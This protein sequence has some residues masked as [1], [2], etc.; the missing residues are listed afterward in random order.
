MNTQTLIKS[1]AATAVVALITGIAA[2]PASAQ[3][4]KRGL[5]KPSSSQA[6]R[7]D[8]KNIATFGNQI[9]RATAKKV[10]PKVLN[11]AK[12]RH[13]VAK[14]AMAEKDRSLC[15][16]AL[17][18]GH[19]MLNR[20]VNPSGLA[21][22]KHCV[23]GNFKRLDNMISTGT[24]RK[25]NPRSIGT[26]KR[27]YATAKANAKKNRPVCGKELK[28]GLN[29]M[30]VVLGTKPGSKL[31]ANALAISHAKTCTRR[32]LVNLEKLIKAG[33]RKKVDPKAIQAAKREYST[34][35][36]FL[37]RNKT[38]CGQALK[39]GGTIMKTALRAA[40]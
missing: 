28:A 10:N 23:P 6:L 17:R 12:F 8:V 38:S 15:T 16:V 25:L 7:C 30:N 37:N 32:N 36:K 26:A 24:K 20:A 14:R 35:K 11:A 29:L 33:T 1:V 9:K 13:A 4:K 27:H 31:N 19:A 3:S 22:A 2:D 39:N 34:A 18:S 21:N 40:R 5:K